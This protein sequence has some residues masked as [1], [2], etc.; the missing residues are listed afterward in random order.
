[1]LAEGTVIHA[2]RRLATAEGQLTEEATGK[3]LAHAT[4]GCMLIS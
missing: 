4:T 2:G 1:V 3:L